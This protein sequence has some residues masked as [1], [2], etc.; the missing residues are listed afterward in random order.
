MSRT[1]KG[2]RPKHRRLVFVLVGLGLLGSAAALG[3]VALR[4]S[5]VFFFTP[6]DV[7]ARTLD[8][9]TRVRIGGLVETG[10]V[11]REQGSARIRFRITDLTHTIAVRYEGLVPDLFREGQGVVVQGRLVEGLF[12]ADEVLAKHDENYMPP[13]VAEAIKKSGQWKADGKM[14]GQ[15]TQ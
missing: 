2:L 4:D 13:E 8:E 14:S 15:K 9:T 10:S 6:T 1:G 5:V 7:Q 11:E 12:R 3:F